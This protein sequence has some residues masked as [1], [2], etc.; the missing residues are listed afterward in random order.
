MSV[1]SEATAIRP[2]RIDVP[3]EEVDDLRRR[4]AATPG[5]SGSSS[6][7]RPRACSRRRC[8]RSRATGSTEY[9]WRRVEAE[10]NALPQFTTEIDGL[11]IHFI[12]VRSQHENAL[13]LII[14]HGWPGLGHRDA[15]GHRAADGPDGVRR[16]APRTRSTS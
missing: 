1:V 2:F 12:H 16:T 9:D 4:V 7:M 3:D 15:R 14:T 8:R 5:P 10:L 11:D 13:P 6:T